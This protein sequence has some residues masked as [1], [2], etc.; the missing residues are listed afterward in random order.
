MT[1]RE[2]QAL[3]DQMIGAAQRLERAA[4]ELTAQATLV[5]RGVLHRTM[6]AELWAMHKAHDIRRT[7]EAA[8]ADLTGGPADHPH[9]H[10]IGE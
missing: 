8:L 9:Q 3:A 1:K 6:T 7:A 5:R 4:R 2:Q 10:V